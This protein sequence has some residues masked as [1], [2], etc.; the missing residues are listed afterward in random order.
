MHKIYGIHPELFVDYQMDVVVKLSGLLEAAQG[1]IE[2][3]NIARS[4]KH[5]FEKVIKEIGDQYD[6]LKPKWEALQSNNKEESK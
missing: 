1:A 4:T 6:A 2:L 5:E 3:N